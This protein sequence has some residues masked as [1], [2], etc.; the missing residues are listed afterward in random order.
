ML[1]V[2]NYALGKKNFCCWK[3][4]SFKFVIV[5]KVDPFDWFID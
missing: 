5:D 4:I 3:E 2:W 1:F